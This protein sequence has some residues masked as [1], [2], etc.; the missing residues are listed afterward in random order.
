MFHVSLAGTPRNYTIP[1]RSPQPAQPPLPAA[2][3]ISFGSRRINTNH[4]CRTIAAVVKFFWDPGRAQDGTQA[5]REPGDR[6]SGKEVRSR[7]GSLAAHF[8][9]PTRQGRSASRCLP[10]IIEMALRLLQRIDRPASRRRRAGPIEAMPA[11]RSRGPGWEKRRL[12]SYWRWPL[13][14]GSHLAHDPLDLIGVGDDH[15]QQ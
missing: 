10:L 13:L 4:H 3:S 1:P 6:N 5:E 14:A 15:A 11:G 2:G 12:R 7:N 9:P 8:D